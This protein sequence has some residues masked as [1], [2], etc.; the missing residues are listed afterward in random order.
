MVSDLN[1][2][3]GDK[4]S[5]GE[6]AKAAD[7]SRATACYVLRNRPGPSQATRDK[8]LKVA[9]QLG[10]APDARINT[11]MT[12]IRDAKSKELVPIA[13]LNTNLEKSAYHSYRFFTPYFEGAQARAQQLGYRLEEMWAHEPGMTMRRMARILYQRGIEGVIVTNPARHFRLN[14][15]RLAGISLGVTL[16]APRLDRVLTDLTYNLLLTM[17]MLKRFGY[18]RIGLCLEKD[19]DN[20]SNHIVNS[21]ARDFHR[22]IP[23]ANPIPPLFYRKE[24]DDDWS[25]TRKQLS[26]WMKVHRPDVI[27]GHSNH[28]VENIEAL[29]YR[30][31]QDVG[32][33]LLIPKKK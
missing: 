10:Y 18:R 6:V 1:T 21:V 30:V 24:G 7:V 13:W 23:D 15:D 2:K 9:E 17:K 32:K 31:P 12:R 25:V 20:F 8:V 14:W 11:W 16:L 4:V 19:V 28:L 22:F 29:G 26:V 33:T 3:R 27:I 5:L